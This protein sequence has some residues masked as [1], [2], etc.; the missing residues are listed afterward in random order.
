MDNDIGD[1]D[2][3]AELL[4]WVQQYQDDSTTGGNQ[5]GYTQAQSLQERSDSSLLMDMD[6]WPASSAA[7][8]PVPAHMHPAN[9]MIHPLDTETMSSQNDDFVNNG[10]MSHA[11]NQTN[12]QDGAHFSTQHPKTQTQP[13]ESDLHRSQSHPYVMKRPYQE[14]STQSQETEQLQ[15]QEGSE[16]RT[17]FLSRGLKGGSAV[18]AHNTSNYEMQHQQHMSLPGPE[19]GLHNTILPASSRSPRT[20]SR[21]ADSLYHGPKS[22]PIDNN[23][24]GLKR[25][26]KKDGIEP[27]DHRESS[28]TSRGFSQRALRGPDASMEQH[29]GVHSDP[30]ESAF[31]PA[32]PYQQVEGNASRGS[33]TPV[34]PMNPSHNGYPRPPVSIGQ[35]SSTV[36]LEK[37]AH[38]NS[39][40]PALSPGRSPYVPNRRSNSDPSYG[41]ARPAERISLLQRISDLE[42]EKAQLLQRFHASPA[43]CTSSKDSLKALM[44]YEG[45]PLIQ[46]LDSFAHM[47]RFFSFNETWSVHKSQ[48]RQLETELEPTTTLKMLLW[49]LLQDDDFYFPNSSSS[50][51]SSSGGSASE[52]SKS[53]EA[54]ESDPSD[55]A[56]QR[57]LGEHLANASAAGSS[58]SSG[59]SN[60]VKTGNGEASH[61]RQR[62]MG[63]SWMMLCH[64]L[65]TDLSRKGSKFQEMRRKAKSL[66]SQLLLS[67][68]RIDRMYDL[69]DTH[70]EE[71]DRI[72][73]ALLNAMTP[74][75]RLEL[76]QRVEDRGFPN[77]LDAQA[78]SHFFPHLSAWQSEG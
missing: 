57:N 21:S 32:L 76:F 68:Y 78:P 67:K 17:S 28:G 59:S 6:R 33:F 9:G 36:K 41:S 4:D 7:N 3:D 15:T 40:S 58:K 5:Q 30:N 22:Q 39:N 42:Q 19:D 56:G 55:K 8:T 64:A 74:E 12:L 16:Q 72:G 29:S 75:Q 70:S 35:R 27:S 44:A 53:A 23:F 20:P 61:G 25:R 54:T 45:Q 46:H 37:E 14:R 66:A 34:G 11:Q 65:E 60:G 26:R 52:A 50:G 48:L 63:N 2:L 51:P 38:T 18:V 47:K 24:E 71:I 31:H 69:I 77:P 13:L 62:N 10:L 49:A 43:R 73:S 1:I